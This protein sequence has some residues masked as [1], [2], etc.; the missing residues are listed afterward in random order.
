MASS[1]ALGLLSSTRDHV[2]HSMLLPIVA[3]LTKRHLLPP[4]QALQLLSWS[5]YLS[6]TE[7]PQAPHF[8]PSSP[9]TAVRAKNLSSPSLLSSRDGPMCDGPIDVRPRSKAV[10]IN[11]APADVHFGYVPHFP[12]LW[13]IPYFSSSPNFPSLASSSDCRSLLVAITPPTKMAE[14]PIGVPPYAGFS[15]SCSCTSYVP[16]F[17][18]RSDPEPHRRRRR[19]DAASS[20][21]PPMLAGRHLAASS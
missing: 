2:A 4:I 15:A 17:P 19:P 8:R 11:S 10:A 13:Y 18:N 9:R 16:Y 6:L 7:V 20:S 12:L 3:N 14:P 1:R 21:P 5:S